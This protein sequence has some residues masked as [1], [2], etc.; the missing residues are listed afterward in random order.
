[1]ANLEE[2]LPTLLSGL[3][4]AADALASTMGEMRT[5]MEANDT[6]ALLRLNDELEARLADVQQAETE[7]LELLQS[8]GLENSRSGM[9][10]LLQATGSQKARELWSD[11]TDQLKEI[12]RLTR[13]N[14]ELAGKSSRHV[15]RVLQLLTGTAHSGSQ[16]Y[17]QTG[18]T[19]SG[20]SKRDI[21]QA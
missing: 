21:A 4:Q 14:T 15:S 11:I 7:R 12:D 1:M 8:Q 2:R 17:D 3:N 19:S 20:S 6:D 5:A 13:I 18:N 10:S 16:T 9:D